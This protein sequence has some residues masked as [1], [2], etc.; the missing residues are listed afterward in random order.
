ME[1]VTANLATVPKRIK[2]CIEAVNSLS[3]Q[4]DLV[5]VYCNGHTEAQ[6][7]KISDGVGRNVEI[8][9]SSTSMGDRGDVGKFY[10]ADEPNQLYLSCD[11]DLLYPKDYVSSLKSSFEKYG[12][13]SVLTYHGSLLRSPMFNY[14]ACRTS[15]ACLREHV[16]DSHV[17]IGGSGVM[18]FYTAEL[19]VDLD[20]F[21]HPNMSDIYIS[22]LSKQQGF[23]IIVLEHRQ[24]WIKYNEVPDTIYNKHRNNCAIQTELVKRHYDLD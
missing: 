6:I 2:Q 3:G 14:Y 10:F 11:D 5:R 18:A 20:F 21:E 23:P 15:Y 19:I 13:K 22:I 12:R 9:D 24:G 8:Y 17:D 16:G 7:M 1:K 4:V